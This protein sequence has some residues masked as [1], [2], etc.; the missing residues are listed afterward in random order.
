MIRI[1]TEFGLNIAVFISTLVFTFLVTKI[2]RS[3]KI[4][5]RNKYLLDSYKNNGEIEFTCKDFDFF[6]HDE[7]YSK[8]L[9]KIDISKADIIRYDFNK[10]ASENIKHGHF[11]KIAAFIK[12]FYFQ[13]IPNTTL[14]I[15]ESAKDID[16]SKQY[17]FV[18]YGVKEISRSRKDIHGKLEA[19]AL[20]MKLT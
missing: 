5:R 12:E 20:Y 19:A 6:D 13:Q 10:S 17:D 1:L 8:E 14:F 18:Q 2:S 15:E 3:R 16:L 7:C 9:I 4:A 11:K